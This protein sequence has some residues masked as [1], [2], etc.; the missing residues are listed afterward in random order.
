MTQLIRIMKA[1]NY[2]TTINSIR[3]LF[4]FGSSLLQA[5]KAA[6]FL[7]HHLLG[8]W[9]AG[10]I[11]KA[12]PCM[13]TISYFEKFDLRLSIVLN[14]VRSHGPQVQYLPRSLYPGS[15]CWHG[16]GRSSSKDLPVPTNPWSDSS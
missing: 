11:I 15:L 9:F 10:R 2:N 7:Q 4:G 14:K 3:K 12:T 5:E 16:C 1:Q 8:C 6:W 13:N